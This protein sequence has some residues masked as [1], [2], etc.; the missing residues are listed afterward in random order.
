MVSAE[1]PLD[2][3]HFYIGDPSRDEVAEVLR[4]NM[5]SLAPSFQYSQAALIDCAKQASVYHN[6]S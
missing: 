6:P 3:V 1:F 4:C 2:F 5:S